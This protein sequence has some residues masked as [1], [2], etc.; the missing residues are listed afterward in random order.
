[1]NRI[2]CWAEIHDEQ[3]RESVVAWIKSGSFKSYA[4]N[5]PRVSVVYEGS[6]KDP[7]D[8]SK[9]WGLIHFFEHYPEHGIYGHDS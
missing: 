9:Q 5:G 3:E 1:M 4:V 2:E 7:D 6:S 8:S